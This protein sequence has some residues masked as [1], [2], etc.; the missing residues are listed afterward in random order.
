[1]ARFKRNVSEG[2]K[3]QSSCCFCPIT[4]VICSR[5]PRA[6]A[7][8]TRLWRIAS[9]TGMAKRSFGLRSPSAMGRRTLTLNMFAKRSVAV[10]Q[11]I[12][13]PSSR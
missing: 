2:G 5:N 1:M 12:S 9:S 11:M 4:R 6:R 13:S 7:L 3:S 8:G 10:P